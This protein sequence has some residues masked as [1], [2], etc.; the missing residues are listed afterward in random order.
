[1]IGASLGAIGF[2]AGALAAAPTTVA[3]VGGEVHPVSESVINNGTV[4]IRGERIVAV[5]A[6]ISIP[7]DAIVIPAHGRVV[8]PGL[9]A[10]DTSLG[11]ME[12]EAEPSSNDAT[13]AVPYPIRAALRADD[14]FDIASALVGVAR[15]HG[16]TSV[17]SAPQ[18]GLISGRGGFF[19]LQDATDF[20]LGDPFRGLAGLYLRLGESGALAVGHSRLAAIG[21]LRQ[22]L[23]DVRTYS[24]EK[25]GA[26]SSHGPYRLYAG[27]NDLVATKPVLDRKLPLVVEVHRAS[28]IRRV[29]RFL[30]AERLRGVLLGASEGWLVAK[31]IAQAKI[32]VVVDPQANLPS[33]FETREARSDN[34]ALMARA[35]VEVIVTARSSHNAGNLRFSLGNAV[36]FGLG[37]KQALRSATLSVA[38]AFGQAA[39]LG[40]LS[41]GKVANVVVWTGDPFEPSSYAEHVLIRGRVQPV[42]SRQTRL[43]NRYINKLGL[44]SGKETE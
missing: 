38:N 4:L 43:A 15:R 11:L 35:G 37:P 21:A 19:D 13:V 22:F 17:I 31:E 3:I 25:K 33:R 7:S 41:V 12:I 5:G 8:T 10:A 6:N 30:R 14:A 16:V 24:R 28:D 32:P 26:L 34:P 39:Q 2:I 20:D 36:R 1:M 27:Q 44:R 29:L 23:A 18:G 9:I 42:D 40:S